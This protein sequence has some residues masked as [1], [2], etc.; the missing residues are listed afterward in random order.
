MRHLVLE[1]GKRD[2]FATSLSDLLYSPTLITGE[3][4]LVHRREL[5][6]QW[7]ERLKTFLS[8][9]SSQVG[10]I[11]AQSPATDISALESQ[12]NESREEGETSP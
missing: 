7:V 5:L 4:N 6:A 11:G 10:T 3:A 12:A 1:R 8:L 9:D 2:R